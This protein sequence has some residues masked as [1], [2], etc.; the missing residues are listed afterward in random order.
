MEKISIVQT[1][2]GVRTERALELGKADATM[3]GLM[4]ER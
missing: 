2:L 3:I 1:F 4:R